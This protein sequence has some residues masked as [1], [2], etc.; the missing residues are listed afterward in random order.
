MKKILILFS[1]LVIAILGL[2]YGYFTYNNSAN[3]IKKEN[4]EYQ[5]YY[6]QE[7]YGAELAT[8]INKAINSNENNKVEKDNK[9]KYIE[10]E[11]NSIKIEIILLLTEKTYPMEEIYNK[12]TAEFVK[13]FNLEKFECTKIEYHKK[14][15][16]VSKLLFEQVEQK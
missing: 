14:T 15:G 8:I 13:Y 3:K 1:A 4:A 5:K 6:E 7:I 9:G 12:N 10:N 11:E 2:I 16:K